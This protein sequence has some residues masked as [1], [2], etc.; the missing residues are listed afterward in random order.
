M[1]SELTVADPRDTPA[2]DP[3]R[4]PA[5][6]RRP[7]RLAIALVAAWLVPLGAYALHQ[8]WLLPPLVLLAT[9][10]LLRGGRTLLDRLLLALLLL[11]GTTTVAGLLFSVWPWG[12]HPVPVNGTAFTVLTVTA[13]A[14]GRRPV[15]PRPGW[16]DLFPLAGTTALLGYLAMPVLRA[17]DLTDRLTILGAGEDHFRH[18]PL[19]D[20]IGRLGGYT[21]LDRGAAHEQIVSVL[22]YYPQGWHLTTALLDRHLGAAA[23]ADA[24]GRY[25]G[26]SLAGFG[27]LVLTVLWAAQRLPG[28]LHP[29]HRGVLTVVV[30]ALILGSQLPRLLISGYP[31]EALGLTLTVA[32]ATL[33]VRPLPGVREQLVLLGALLVGIGFTYYFFL[34]P[35]GL[36]VLGWLA[37]HRRELARVRRTLLAVALATAAL[38]P[39]PLLVGVLHDN[40][41]SALSAPGGPKVAESWRA[42][43]GLGLLVVAVLAVRIRHSDPAWRRHL[44]VVL[45]GV[46]YALAIAL[47]TVVLGGEPAYYFM[48]AA[49]LATVFLLVGVAGAIRLLPVPRADGPDRAVRVRSVVTVA[50][51]AS[52]AMATVLVLA[53]VVGRPRSLLTSGEANWARVWTTR[54]EGQPRRV[55]EVCARAY[56]RYPAVPG[57]VTLILDRGPYRGYVESLCLSALQG[58][59]AQTERGIY[60]PVFAE[61]E[62]IQKT[63]RRVPGPV[64]FVVTDPVA[65]QRVETLLRKKPELRDR[66]STV[67]ML[68]PQ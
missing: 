3:H 48:K 19:V 67:S 42:L 2:V 32:V 52:L 16:L 47:T 26:W 1:P 4:P 8:P 50:L 5:A 45:V 29:L 22:L 62:R 68:V 57:T 54:H 63:V 39:L 10:S 65:Q 38:A 40:Q 9:A 28:P 6:G 31:T 18:L 44:A 20:V 7:G 59:T 55:G 64:R 41:A 37:G 23:G 43:L 33:V 46:G 51:A 21:F 34:P 24:V 25:L 12:L 36:L 60:L 35:A 14:T 56:Q 13:A 58:T 27:L 53:G 49:H 66:V 30:G 61:P 17:R 11:V 15:L